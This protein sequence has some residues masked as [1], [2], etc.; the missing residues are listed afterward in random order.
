MTA[1]TPTYLKAR[2][3]TGDIPTGTDYSDVF[4]SYLNVV[5]TDIQTIAGGVTFSNQIN[6]SEVITPLVSAASVIAS[7]V[8]A[9]TINGAFINADSLSVSGKV[10]FGSVDI[11]AAS[12]TQAGATTLG[13]VTNFVIYAN[14]NNLAVKLPTSESG[15][16]Q[17]IINAASTTLKIFPAV[18]G[19]F[20]VTAVN[21]SLNLPADKT[22]LVF[23]KGDDRYGIVIGGF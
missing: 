14:G 17:Y 4:D 10:I 23:H 20:L 19:R 1:Q 3:E 21:A 2:F 18:S 15:R 11:S 22:A 5:T 8:S 16:Q 7:F 9:Q 13:G 6:V 12:T